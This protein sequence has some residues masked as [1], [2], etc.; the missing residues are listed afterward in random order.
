MKS[1]TLAL[2]ALAAGLHVSGAVAYVLVPKDAAYLKECG[3]CH[4]AFSPQLLPAASW[5]RIMASLDNHFG[6]SAKV[7]AATQQAITAYLVDNA[8]D[9]AASDES[10]VIMHSLGPGEVPGRITEIPFVAGV[11]AAALDPRWNG[12][13]RPKRLTECETCHVRAPKGDYRIQAFT[14]TDEAFSESKGRR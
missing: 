7:D 5:R 10:R 4:T 11:H 1:R 3:S 6:D 8:A 2:L 12:Q 13:P 14:V 9:H